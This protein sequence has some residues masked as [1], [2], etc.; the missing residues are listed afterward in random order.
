MAHSP[1][2]RAEVRANYIYKSMAMPQ[3]AEMAGIPLGTARAWKKADELAGKDWDVQRNA[4]RM[5]GGGVAAMAN[6]VLEELAVQ[7][8]ATLKALKEDEKLKASERS[9]I[10]VQLMDGYAKAI[11]ASSRAMPNANRLAVAMDVVRWITTLLGQH[12]PEMR[13]H[14][15]AIIE[16]AGDAMVREFGGAA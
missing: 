3:A 16:G 6:E 14:F 10:M 13:E 2:K 11:S 4:R 1:E 5:T 12:A 8:Q 15:L 7:F 9:R